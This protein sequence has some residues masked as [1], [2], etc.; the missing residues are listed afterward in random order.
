MIIGRRILTLKTDDRDI[1]IPVTIHAPA[2]EAAEV[3][4]CRY[5]VGWPEGARSYAGWGADAIQALVSA[6]NMS[7]AEI[8]SSSYHKSGHLVWD[9]PGNGYGFP[10]VSGLRDLLVGDDAKY[11]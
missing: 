7:G 9:Q 6:L 8:Y 10:V 3:W 11:L 1:E 2:S 5:D 4:F